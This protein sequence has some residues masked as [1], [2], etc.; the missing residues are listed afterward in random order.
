MLL[1]VSMLMA[2]CT[3]D[4][5]P[6]RREGRP[7]TRTGRDGA[8]RRIAILD[9]RTI[10]V[11]R[12]GGSFH[13]A[14]VAPERSDGFR[15]ME[16]SDRHHLVA[17]VSPTDFSVG[18]LV[19]IDVRTGRQHDL[20]SG[21]LITVHDGKVLAA[22]I[23]YQGLKEPS[24]MTLKVFDPVTRSWQRLSGYAPQSKREFLPIIDV[25]STKG[26]RLVVE[27]SSVDL[28]AQ[29]TVLLIDLGD[30]TVSPFGEVAGGGAVID[31]TFA[32]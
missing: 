11:G 31:A 13:D 18:S 26:D 28:T 27:D 6:P 8:A 12:L 23:E 3:S 20:G 7:E 15:S 19:E 14:A 30:G 10:R 25:I 5:S 2:S 17:G 29:P 22:D 21:D 1:L 4:G 24:V 16:W 9:G 32:P